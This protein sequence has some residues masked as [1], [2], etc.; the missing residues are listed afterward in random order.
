MMAPPGY[1]NMVSSPSASRLLMTASAPVIFTDSSFVRTSS[2]SMEFLTL[3]IMSVLVILVCYTAF[4][5]SEYQCSIVVKVI[6]GGPYGKGYQ[7]FPSVFRLFLEHELL[8][9]IFFGVEL[10]DI[11]VFHL[12]NAPAYLCFWSDVSY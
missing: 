11:P 12:T 2:S 7:V 3:I 1:P 4:A 6:I 5:I 10:D 9:Q 8:D